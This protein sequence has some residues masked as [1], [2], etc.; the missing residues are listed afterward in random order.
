MWTQ[1][2]WSFWLNFGLFVHYAFKIFRRIEN[3]SMGLGLIFKV[4]PKLF[5][6]F[7]TSLSARMSLPK[8]DNNKQ[9][10]IIILNTQIYAELL[11]YFMKHLIRC[12]WMILMASVVP[13]FLHLQSMSSRLG[14]RTSFRL[15][16]SLYF[17]KDDSPAYLGS[18]GI[19]YS[20]NGLNTISY[21]YFFLHFDEFYLCWSS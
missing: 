3:V 10:S 11:R 9:S 2:N 16:A 12:H 15:R 13:Q 21:Q 4:N 14:I 20:L 19:A 17:I 6:F 18:N 8:W 5:I 1:S 7:Q